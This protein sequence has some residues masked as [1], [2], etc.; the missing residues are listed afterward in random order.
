MGHWEVW[1]V[2]GMNQ[3]NPPSGAIGFIYK[4]TPKD[5]TQGL[6]SYIGKK[7]LKNKISKKPLKGKKNKRIDYIESNWKEYTGSSKELNE[8]INQRGK[9][10]FH[11]IILRWCFSKWEL[12]YFEGEAQF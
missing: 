7:Q 11:F 5:S 12:S 9:Q 10:D 6:K 2:D 3:D 8:I 1:P 4:I